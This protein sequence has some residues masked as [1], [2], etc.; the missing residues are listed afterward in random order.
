MH[1]VTTKHGAYH[2]WKVF[3]YIIIHVPNGVFVVC[4]KTLTQKTHIK[5]IRQHFKQVY[6]RAMFE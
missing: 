4:V 1:F 6:L 5:D 2:M 3:R